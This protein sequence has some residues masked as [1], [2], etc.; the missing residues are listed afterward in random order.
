MFKL[1]VFVFVCPTIL[2]VCLTILFIFFL[3]FNA[4][5]ITNT[6]IIIPHL[7]GNVVPSCRWMIEFC[8]SCSR[9]NVVM[10]M[11]IL[12]FIITQIWFHNIFVYVVRTDEIVN[13][14][15]SGRDPCLNFK[16]IFRRKEEYS[17]TTFQDAKYVFDN[18]SSRCVAKV[19]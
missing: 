4:P 16:T 19:E 10:I 8:S 12:C 1:I 9:G 3:I 17:E 7:L 18:V 5:L 11:I 15:Q 2:F 13:G 6:H 14:T